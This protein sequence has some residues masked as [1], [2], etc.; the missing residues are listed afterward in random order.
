MLEAEKAAD[1]PEQQLLAKVRSVAPLDAATLLL[2]VQTPRSQRLRFFAGQSATLAVA[3]GT[4]DFGGDYP[5]ASCPCDDRNLLFHIARDEADEFSQRLFAGAVRAGDPISLRGPYGS[6]ALKKDSA[7]PILFACCDAGF[8]PT[9]SLVEH[10][11]AVDAAE[12]VALCWVTT[13]PGGHYAANQCRAWA[14]AL[15]D[16]RWLPREAADAAGAAAALLAAAAG[17]PDL[18]ARDVYLAG[19]PDFVAAATQGLAAAGVPADQLLS[20]VF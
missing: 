5:I 19:P 13:R 15:D 8:A 9:N 18:A 16:F 20:A 6:F 7:R 14:G 10:A 4:A 1:I 2:H 17:L 11:I 12:S 3:G